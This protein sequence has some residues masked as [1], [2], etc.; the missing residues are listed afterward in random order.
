MA[1]LSRPFQQKETTQ[2]SPLQLQR[3]SSGGGSHPVRSKHLPFVCSLGWLH[4]PVRIWGP[5]RACAGTQQSWAKGLGQPCQAQDAQ[6]HAS[7]PHQPCR[8]MLRHAVPCH[9]RPAMLPI[10][11]CPL[12][13]GCGGQQSSPWHL[14]FPQANCAC[15]LQTQEL[16]WQ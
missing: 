5:G 12:Y 11:F 9:Q 15:P 6:S 7:D 16:V 1:M 3:Q 4:L 13:G 8:A 14:D 2:I 10:T